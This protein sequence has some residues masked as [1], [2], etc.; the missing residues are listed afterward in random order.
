MSNPSPTVEDHATT[1]IDR[2]R[3]TLFRLWG[4]M[5]GKTWGEPGNEMAQTAHRFGEF[6]ERH[7]ARGRLQSSR[8]LRNSASEVPTEP[9]FQSLLLSAANDL[10]P[11]LPTVASMV[12]AA[13][14]AYEAAAAELAETPREQWA[15]PGCPNRAAAR[16]REEAVAKASP[17]LEMRVDLSCGTAWP[18]CAEG[19]DTETGVLRASAR[20][21]YGPDGE[22]RTPMYL[23]MGHVTLTRPMV[24]RLFEWI[25]RIGFLTCEAGGALDRQPMEVDDFT[26]FEAVARG[27]DREILSEVLEDL[28]NP[29]ISGGA[30]VSEEDRER[31]RRN[32]Q[33]TLKELRGMNPSLSAAISTGPA[34]APAE[35]GGI[36]Q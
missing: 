31:A 19:F 20:I 25:G 34:P 8:V 5:E 29:R 27:E 23:V 2:T 21:E 11:P 35:M 6:V 4:N 17:A 33:A 26:G 7:K 15:G 24:L 18:D 12:R 14:E 22:A 9:G 16:S 1:E 32:V 30:D 13:S 10:G 3:A 28:G 36:A